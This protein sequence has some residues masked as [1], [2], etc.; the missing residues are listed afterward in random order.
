MKNPSGWFQID[1][2][3]SINRVWRRIYIIGGGLIVGGNRK[4]SMYEADTADT[5]IE[6]N[7]GTATRTRGRG[8]VLARFARPAGPQTTLAVVADPHVTARATGTWKVFHRTEARLRAA[9]REANRL[10]VDGVVFL[11]DLTKD[12]APEE[13]DRV[14]DL[15]SELRVPFV[16]VPGNHDVQ[17]ADTPETP[18]LEAFEAAYTPGSLPFCERVGSVD[19]IGLNSA[20]MPDESLSDTHTGAISTD[21]LAWLD[22]TLAEADN[23]VVT[24]HHTVSG[25]ASFTD[26]LGDEEHYRIRNPTALVDVL[27]A[28][29]VNLVLS[30]HVHWPVV[31]RLRS[32]YELTA[33]AACSFPQAS[34][35]VSVEPRGTT[36]SV[37]P[38]TDQAGY[39]EAYRHAS[40]AEGR[41]Q[42]M[43][44]RVEDGFFASFPLVDE[45]EQQATTTGQ[46]RPVAHT[47]SDCPQQEEH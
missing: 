30:G 33:P 38:L 42:I 35:L 43:T 34:L 15:L 20:S 8:P 22:S 45:G 36:V 14:D 21:Q 1:I 2:I 9:I 28:H 44:E 47:V 46:Q 29:E 24:L 32:T 18:A 19:L 7:D 39:M 23:P 26:E 12:G 17:K 25:A 13:F 6:D 4:R 31:N 41:S 37:V 40:R 11:G 3:A 10:G 16:A 5:R 27:A